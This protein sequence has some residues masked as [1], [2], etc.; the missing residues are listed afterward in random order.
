MTLQLDAPIDRAAAPACT[1][2]RAM[3]ADAALLAAFAARTFSDTYAR[4]NDPDNFARHL[5]TAFHPERQAGELAN[6]DIATLLA[7]RDGA[8]AGYA[9]VRRADAPACVAEAA[10]IELHRFYVDAAWHGGGV[11]QRLFVE[12]CDAA[13][14]FGG[15][16]LWLKVWERNARALA[17]YAKSGF[18]D[19]GTADFLLGDDRQTDRVLVRRLAAGL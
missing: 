1:I 15:A 13:L 7:H 11:A 5:A 3:P 19:V 12:A 6:S 14:A 10:P 16:V 17:F 2:R 18:V 8:L 4:Y 9:Q